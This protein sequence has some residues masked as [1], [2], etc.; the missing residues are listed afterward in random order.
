MYFFFCLPHFP[1]RNFISVAR[2]STPSD[3][4]PAHAESFF[5]FQPK[6]FIYIIYIHQLTARVGCAVAA[7]VSVS[8]SRFQFPIKFHC[9]ARATRVRD[10]FADVGS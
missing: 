6:T 4:L 9:V 7:A 1:I 10:E 2:A 5:I 8:Y 3:Y